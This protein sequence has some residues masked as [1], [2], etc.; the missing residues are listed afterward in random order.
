MCIVIVLHLPLIRTRRLLGDHHLP[1]SVASLGAGKPA[2]C[3]RVYPRGIVERLLTA[4]LVA[5]RHETVSSQ[6]QEALRARVAIERAVGVVI[7]DLDAEAAFER[8]R[9]AARSTRRPVRAV[10][11][12]ITTYKK[13]V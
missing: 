13:L 9:R 6:L 7:E 12:Q 5:K 4:A 3:R 8:I 2:G 1:K 11:A 10:A